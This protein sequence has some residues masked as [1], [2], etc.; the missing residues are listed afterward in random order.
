MA[1]GLLALAM[2]VPALWTVSAEAPSVCESIDCRSGRGLGASEAAL[3]NRIDDH[4]SCLALE[5]AHMGF[6]P[7][8]GEL[9]FS[10]SLRAVAEIRVRG[11]A[12]SLPHGPAAP[13]RR[14]GNIFR[15]GRICHVFFGFPADARQVLLAGCLHVCSKG[16]RL[17]G[18]HLSTTGRGERAQDREDRSGSHGQPSKAGAR[19]MPRAKGVGAA[20]SGIVTRRGA[21]AGER[22]A[23]CLRDSDDSA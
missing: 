12:V 4:T 23:H 19:S 21:D 1:A 6:G 14:S 11:R 20:T 18:L 8:A 22:Y 15:S 7:V 17:A 16:G 5:L 10:G 13:V 3:D 2:A 9:P